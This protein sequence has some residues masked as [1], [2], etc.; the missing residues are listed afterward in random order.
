MIRLHICLVIILLLKF[1]GSYT[2]LRIPTSD[3][4]PSSCPCPHFSLHLL[5]QHEY[6]HE[7]FFKFMAFGFIFH[8]GLQNRPLIHAVFGFYSFDI[9]ALSDRICKYPLA[10]FLFLP[11]GIILWGT[12]PIYLNYRHLVGLLYVLT[13][14]PPP[15]L[16]RERLDHPNSY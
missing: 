11:L 5:F 13:P 8:S 1:F 9:L 3:P 16:V 6:Q 2:S 4:S 10:A 12:E 15:M 14:G 7:F